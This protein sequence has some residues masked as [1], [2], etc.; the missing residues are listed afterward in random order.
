MQNSRVRNRPSANVFRQ[1]TNPVHI[2]KRGASASMMTVPVIST[3]F[4]G[5]IPRPVSSSHEFV[6]S[7]STSIRLAQLA[8]V[9]HSR[10]PCE[11]LFRFFPR[12]HSPVACLPWHH[13]TD[14]SA[15]NIPSPRP[16]GRQIARRTVSAR[17]MVP[18]LKLQPVQN[19]SNLSS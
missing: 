18:A 1:I 6:V 10:D 2:V 9:T 7:L 3:F 19:R 5:R 16:I 4:N 13:P 11:R 12:A 15:A 17:W 14:Q 8:C